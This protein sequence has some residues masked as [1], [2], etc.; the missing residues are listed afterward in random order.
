MSTR[1]EKS[2]GVAVVTGAA[3]QDGYFLTER[4]LA[5]GGT[6]HAVV[7][8]PAKDIESLAA[9]AAGRLHAEVLDFVDA[10][11]VSEL[12]ASLRPTELYNLAGESSISQSFAEPLRT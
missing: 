2:A 12:V 5:E 7:R 10:D 3:G 8:R 4:L 1:G 6:V 11:R 9:N